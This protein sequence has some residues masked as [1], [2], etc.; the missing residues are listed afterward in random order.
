MISNYTINSMFKMM[1]FGM[2][3]KYDV[4]SGFDDLS[5]YIFNATSYVPAFA[6]L[7]LAV[8]A[9]IAILRYSLYDIDLLINRTLVYGALSAG[10]VGIY[11]FAVVGLGA[12]FQ[13]RGNLPSRWW[14]RES[15]PSC[16]SRF[17]AGSSAA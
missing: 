11:V 13:A 17:G 1:A 4:F 12:L 14:P 16:S 8:F 5:H 6:L 3:E 7:I 2:F 9:C 15:W 10:G